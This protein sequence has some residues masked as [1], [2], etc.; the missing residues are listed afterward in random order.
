M[1]EFRQR[2]FKFRAWHIESRLLVKLSS[3][4]FRKGELYKEGYILLQFT[5]MHDKYGEEIYEADVLLESNLKWVVTWEEDGSGWQLKGA[6]N[7]A[8]SG[9][10]TPERA[11]QLKRL[12]SYFES[13]AGRQPE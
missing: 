3:A 5:G 8:K 12:C 10:L 9:K 11:A 2:S 4:D 1:K 6:D 13:E 7:G